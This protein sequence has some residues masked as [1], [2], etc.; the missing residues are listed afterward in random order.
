MGHNKELMQKC[1]RLWEYASFVEQVNQNLDNGYSMERAVNTAIDTCILLKSR[2]EVLLMFLTEYDEKLHMENTFEE[3]RE[4]GFEQGK[5][6]ILLLSQ[7]LLNENRIDDLKKAY[8]DEQYL[9]SL[10]L[11]F[12]LEKPEIR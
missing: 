12:H 7:I 10:L 1:R 5:Q 9:E 8:T 11:E 3:G 4:T 2:S 6:Q